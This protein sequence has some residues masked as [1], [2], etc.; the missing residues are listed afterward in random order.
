M[1]HFILKSE[2][3]F[4]ETMMARLNQ[5]ADAMSESEKARMRARIEAKLKSG[6]RL[7]PE[8]ERFLQQTD[9]QMYMQYLRIRQMAQALKTQLKQAKTKTQVNR[10]I[11]TALGAVSKDD[12]AREYIIAALTEVA[13]EFKSS[14][15][16]KELPDTEA[17]LAKQKNKK[18]HPTPKNEDKDEVEDEDPFDPMDW[19]PLQDVIDGLPTFDHP[20]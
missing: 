15:A 20:A 5:Q 4:L 16:Y 2:Q 19:S 8:E 11:A 6:K 14:P 10:I 1:D 17:E 13:R 12:P 3:Q 9:P 18:P 7:T